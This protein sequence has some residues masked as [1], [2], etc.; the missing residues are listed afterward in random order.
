M[1]LPFSLLPRPALASRLSVLVLLLLVWPLTGA[2]QYLRYLKELNPT[3]PGTRPV[4]HAEFDALLK[5]HV[6]A[7]GLVNYRAFTADSSQLSAYCNRLSSTLPNDQ[8]WT[9]NEQLAY[10]LNAYNAFTIQRVLR[11][12][13]S[14]SI[15]QLGGDKTLINTVWDQR[16]I[17]LGPEKYC[18]NDLEQRLIRRRFDEYRI[19]FALVC[20]SISCPRLRREAY[21]GARLN[22]QLD[23][24][25]RDFIN[26]PTKNRLT[27]AAAPQVSE[28][29]DFYPGDFK[30]NGNSIVKTLNKYASQP[31]S[32]AAKLKYLPYNWNLNQQ[33]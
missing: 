1:Q 10:W 11:G 7:R 19:H 27:P 22:Q 21:V 2:C 20:A 12:R 32:P 15:R 3:M 24:Q 8:N 26:D 30:K 17:R 28:I 13:P 29:F 16:F 25:A 18:L 33:Q 23:E 14:K 4:S 31:V 6:D 9:R 5:K